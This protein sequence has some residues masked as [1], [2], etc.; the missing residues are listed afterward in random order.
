MAATGQISSTFHFYITNDSGTAFTVTNPGRTFTVVAV[1]VANSNVAARTV[2]IR[3]N[4]NAGDDL[5]IA[6]GGGAGL[7]DVTANTQL[8]IMGPNQGGGAVGGLNV[9]TG[10]NYTASDN[11][12]ID[13]E[14]ADVSPIIIYCQGNPAKNLTVS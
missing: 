10:I 12:W 3:K 11:F 5:L 14:D 7:V 9:A 1:M 6:T 13:P 8:L 2:R 4:N